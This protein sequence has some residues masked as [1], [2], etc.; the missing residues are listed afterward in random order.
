MSPPLGAEA[1]SS[2]PAGELL[3]DVE[4]PGA[5]AVVPVE[6]IPVRSVARPVWRALGTA[7][8]AAADVL[9]TIDHPVGTSSPSA[10]IGTARLLQWHDNPYINWDAQVDASVGLVSADSAV[11]RVARSGRWNW[12]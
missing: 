8:L 6:A 7:L 10:Q 3:A 4:T 11:G 1:S 5:L 12:R 9:L 2:T